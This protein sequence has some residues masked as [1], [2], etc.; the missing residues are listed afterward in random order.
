[1]ILLLA[2]AAAAAVPS[3][4]AGQTPLD[5]EKCDNRPVIMVVEGRIRDAK[6]LSSYAAAIRSSGLYQK[7]GGYYVASPRSVA[8]FEGAPPPERS[9]LL[10]RFPCLAHARAFWNSRMYREQIMPLRLNPSAGDFTVTVH[11]ELPQP[12]YMTG[13]VG[14]A[15]FAPDAGS[16]AGISQVDKGAK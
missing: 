14:P 16:M 9:I 11:M 5:R 10:V 15:A 12:D 6:R 13:R 2:F 4:L 1:V 3:P 8:V 7:L